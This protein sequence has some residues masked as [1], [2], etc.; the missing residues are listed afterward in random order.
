MKRVITILCIASLLSILSS[1]EE[2]PVEPVSTSRFAAYITDEFVPAVIYNEEHYYGQTWQDYECRF[3]VEEQ[4]EGSDTLL[5][6]VWERA[7]GEEM[8]NI[9]MYFAYNYVDKM[10]WSTNETAAT[11]Y[12]KGEHTINHGS[13]EL[14]DGERVLTVSTQ[15]GLYVVREGEIVYK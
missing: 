4:E 12:F 5:I 11:V 8:I 9:W 3:K 15:T 7:G 2:E 10:F 13:L 1:C 6:K 14:V